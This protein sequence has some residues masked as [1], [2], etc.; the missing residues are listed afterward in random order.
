MMGVDQDKK[1]EGKLTKTTR[2]RY[3]VNDLNKGFIPPS[4]N[5]GVIRT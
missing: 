1:E 3:S 4:L 5:C 2:D